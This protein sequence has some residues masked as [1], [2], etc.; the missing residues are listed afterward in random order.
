[1]KCNITNLQAMSQLCLKSWEYGDSTAPEDCFPQSTNYN[2][3]ITSIWCMIQG[4]V[5]ITGNLLTLL[6]I[7][8][9]AKKKK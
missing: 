4:F 3:T 8:Y 9:A 1:M 2:G 5:G 6:A 7:P